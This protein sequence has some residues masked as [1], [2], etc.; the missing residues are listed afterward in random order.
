MTV[1]LGPDWEL[2]TAIVTAL[3]ASAN[4]KSLIGDPPRI[5]QEIPQGAWPGAY[6]VMGEGDCHDDSAQFLTATNVFPKIHVWSRSPSWA[7][8]KKIATVVWQLLHN[9]TISLSEN[10]FFSILLDQ[11]VAMKD[12][13]GVSRHIALTYRARVET[14]A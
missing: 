13:D 6:V 8:A 9:Q 2:Q 4:L 5:Y 7:E 1:S 10:R 3:N 11:S 12:P 14:P